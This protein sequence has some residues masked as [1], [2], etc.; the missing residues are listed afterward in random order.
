MAVARAIAMAD[1]DLRARLRR[2]ADDM[3]YNTQLLADRSERL[4]AREAELRALTERLGDERREAEGRAMAWEARERALEERA[5]ELRGANEALERRCEEQFREMQA[6]LRQR[7]EERAAAEPARA[8]QKR[9]EQKRAEPAPEAEDLR[10]ELRRVHAREM[11][12][13]DRLESMIMDLA[14]G[15]CERLAPKRS[16]G[17]EPEPEPVPEPDGDEA[18]RE[19]RGDAAADA[20]AEGVDGDAVGVRADVPPAA[21]EAPAAAAATGDDVREGGAEEEEE[22]EGGRLVEVLSQ[23]QASE[24]RQQEQMRQ[25]RVYEEKMVA[26]AEKL[27]VLERHM[28]A[29]EA[30]GA[31]AERDR[32]ERDARPARP[33]RPARGEEGQDGEGEPRRGARRGDAVAEVDPLVGHMLQVER[34]IRR[35]RAGFLELHGDAAAAVAAVRGPPPRGRRGADVAAVGARPQYHYHHH[36]HHYRPGPWLP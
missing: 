2:T 19:E 36:R 10:E 6:L 15:R 31:A 16:A 3:A 11:R 35:A 13:H 21:D 30:A 25:L 20:G 26:M 33:A 7:D 4:R 23:L 12:Q 1:V 18:E 34:R 29:P 32:Q 24:A 17:P 8:E 28:S 5:E 9:A 14:Y 27:T 22:E